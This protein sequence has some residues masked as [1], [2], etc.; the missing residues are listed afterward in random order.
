M[1]A[2]MLLLV[3]L[4]A[5]CGGTG[6]SNRHVQSET[7]ASPTFANYRTFA[8]GPATQPVAPFGVS[9]RSFEVERRLRPLVVAELQSKG[10]TEQTGQAKPDF[11]VSFAS[12]YF[13]EEDSAQ[14]EPGAALGVLKGQVVIDAFDVTSEA[15]VWHGTAEAEVDPKKIDDQ[16]LQSAVRR[17]LAPFPT[18]AAVTAPQAP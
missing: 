12:G 16:L 13:R 2:T 1:K 17:V 7:A 3:G 11:M 6:L 4:L 5:A 8:F 14:M 15:Q 18:R 10:Y 9:G